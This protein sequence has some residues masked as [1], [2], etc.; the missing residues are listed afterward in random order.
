ML[1]DIFRDAKIFWTQQATF[2]EKIVWL[3][4]II[5]FFS[6]GWVVMDISRI[7]GF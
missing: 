3:C 2:F 4:F 6:F 5:S 1:K 7:I